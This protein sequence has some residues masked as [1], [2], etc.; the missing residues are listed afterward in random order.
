MQVVINGYNYWDM[1]AEKYWALPKSKDP[2]VEIPNLVFGEEYFAARKIDG[3]WAMIIKDMEGNFHLRARNKGVSGE[4][5]DKVEWIPHIVKEL[6]HLP[7]GTALLGELYIPTHEGSKNV[8]KI[9]GCLLEKS[10]KRQE[11]KDWKL[12]FYIF[13]CLAY[14]GINIMNEPIEKRIHHYLGRELLDVFN[15]NKYSHPA[16]YYEGQK[17]WDYIGE[18]LA[19]GGEGVVLQKKNSVYTPGKRTAWKTCKVKKE[20]GNDL[21]LFFTGRYKPSTKEYNGK[22]VQNWIYWEHL[23]TGEKMYGNY[24]DDFKSGAT[25]QPVSKGYFNGWAGSIE[26]GAVDKQGNIVSVGWI[27]NLTEDVR[28]KVVN[29]E[30]AKQVVKVSAMEIDNKSHSLRH[31]KIVEYRTDKKWTECGIEQLEV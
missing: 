24:Y 21:D 16:K 5:A 1:D 29:G 14:K 6:D 15:N 26:L 20:I 23:R 25:I 4:F 12:H 3:Q 9:A 19:A 8:T 10:L 17:L 11:D 30:M 13:D 22:E 31:G 7:N 18:V 28:E 2:K 27:S